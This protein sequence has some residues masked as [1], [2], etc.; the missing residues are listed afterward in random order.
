VTRRSLLAA[1][2]GFAWA[3]TAAPALA[4]PAISFTLSGATG[5]PGWFVGP[6]TINWSVQGALSSSGC[7]A[8]VQLTADTRGTT[9]TCR[10]SNAEGTATVT[11]SA[12]RID[13]TPPTVTA[14][15]PARPPDGNG[16]YRAPVG[17]AWSGVDATSGIASCTTTTY[18][19]PDGPAAPTGVCRDQAGNTSAPR[20]YSLNY[21]A[22]APALRAVAAAAGDGAVTLGWSPGDA[23]RVIVTRTPGV[24]RVPSSVV[25][26]GAGAGYV[27]S[28]VHNGVGYAYT[29]TAFD[30]AGNAATATATARPRTRL[31]GPRQAAL[32]GAP[33]LLRWKRVIRARYYNVQV[34]R[35]AQK[36]LSTWPRHPRLRMRRTWRYLGRRERLTPGTYR[37]YVWPGYGKRSG[38]RYGRLLGTRQF[39]VRTRAP[40]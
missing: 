7:E 19:G 1:A 29:V 16:F 39:T 25:F 30:A 22:T 2:T 9:R 18:A 3:L 17:I 6:V 38:H 26:N 40:R 14:A 13:R 24:G 36:I 33:P 32:L 5:A 15:G 12:I 35:G 4:A 28:T 23:G 8:A 31:L 37:W 11:T 20:P 21:D 34:F 10:A 27:D